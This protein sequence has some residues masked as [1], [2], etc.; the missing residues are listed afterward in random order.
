MLN[1]ADFPDNDRVSFTLQPNKDG[2]T[3]SVDSAK[4][5]PGNWGV[6]FSRTEEGKIYQRPFGG[7]TRNFGEAPVQRTCAAADRTGHAML[8]TLYGNS[9]KYDVDFLP[10]AQHTIKMGL[11]GTY[12]SFTPSATVIEGNVQDMPF[13]QHHQ[14]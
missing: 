1:E 4:S 12:H 7:M 8:H 10:S 13:V 2:F 9:L 11:V 5:R 3:Y 14:E 6:P